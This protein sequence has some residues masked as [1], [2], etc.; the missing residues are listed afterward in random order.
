MKRSITSIAFIL[1]ITC[2]FGQQNAHW[3]QSLFNYYQINSAYAGSKNTSSIGLSYRSQWTGISG[4][5][6]SQYITYHMPLNSAKMGLG[7]KIE[8]DKIGIT[9]AIKAE[10]AYAYH[11]KLKQGSFSIALDGS[12]KQNT[13]KLSELDLHEPDLVLNQEQNVS[14]LSSGVGFSILY[15]SN[16]FI[17]GIRTSNLN[18]A[19]YKIIEGSNARDHIQTDVLIGIAK[20]L[21]KKIICKPYIIAKHLESNQLSYSFSSNFTLNH[22]LTIGGSYRNDSNLNLLLHFFVRKNLRMGYSYEMGMTQLRT[23]KLN[24]HEIFMGINTG[25]ESG[26]LVSPRF[27]DL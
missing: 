19:H 25:K 1:S 9:G 5:P 26:E 27:Y 16:Y 22:K 17:G 15:Q 12:L 13:F 6:Q 20:R 18:S 4:A 8:N 7:I 24:S 21:S 11:I 3:S 10:L 2:V 23:N 14:R